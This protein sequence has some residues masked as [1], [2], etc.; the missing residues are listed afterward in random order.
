M[1]GAELLRQFL[2]HTPAIWAAF[3]FTISTLA[4]GFYFGATS[5]F[6]FGD[7]RTRLKILEKDVKDIKDV[8][9]TNDDLKEGIRN[10]TALLQADAF[11]QVT[12]NLKDYVTKDEIRVLEAQAK[13]THGRLQ[14]QVDKQE[15]VF[16]DFQR[17]YRQNQI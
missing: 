14:R 17:G 6:I 2:A 7:Y 4:F 3:F 11:K 16:R 5:K 13:E 9:I 12:E 15:E 1:E 8:V 10:L